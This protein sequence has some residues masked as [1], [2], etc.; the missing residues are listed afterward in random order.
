M[1]SNSWPSD[2]PDKPLSEGYEESPP[3]TQIRTAMDQGPDKVRR[4]HTAN[5]TEYQMQLV[6]D[7][8]QL[9]SFD[10]FYKNTTNGGSEKFDW[11]DPRT[12]DSVEFRF[13]VPPTPTYANEGGTIWL[14]RFKLEELP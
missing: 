5:V 1:A 9:K 3:R 4:D 12:G 11:E 6:L 14:V 7:E 2:L 8:E 10:D 13:V